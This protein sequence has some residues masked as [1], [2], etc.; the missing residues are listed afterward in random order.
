MK[1]ILIFCGFLFFVSA[2][3]QKKKKD[4]AKADKTVY[5]YKYRLYRPSDCFCPNPNDHIE[6]KNFNPYQYKEQNPIKI[7][8]ADW[9]KI[10]DYVIRKT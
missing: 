10:K 2:S 5:Q 1:N 9:D 4:S 8:S 3:A 7:D 6:R